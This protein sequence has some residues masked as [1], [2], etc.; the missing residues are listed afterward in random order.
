MWEELLTGLEETHED[1]LIAVREIRRASREKIGVDTLKGG[2]TNS[3]SHSPVL[4]TSHYERFANDRDFFDAAK[5]DNFSIAV[6]EKRYGNVIIRS[7]NENAKK[8]VIFAHGGYT[9]PR[10]GI[11][12]GS[13]CTIT[14]SETAIGFNARHDGVGIFTRALHLLYGYEPSVNEEVRGGSEIINYSLM[15]DSKAEAVAP[16]EEYDVV[17]ISPNGKAHMSDIFSSMR[18]H[19]CRYTYLYSVACRINKQIPLPVRRV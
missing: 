18:E 3:V 4:G 19:D 8:A 9:P 6:K 11:L 2:T 14:P 17:V 12:S 13:G 10:Y 1:E 5:R 7:Q 16:N 15:H